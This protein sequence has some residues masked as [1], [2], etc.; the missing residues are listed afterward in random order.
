MKKIKEHIHSQKMT[1]QKDIYCIVLAKNS[2]INYDADIKNA[3]HRR[4]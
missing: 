2:D 4:L 3:G 1:N